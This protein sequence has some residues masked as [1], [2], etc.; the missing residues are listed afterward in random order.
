MSSNFVPAYSLIFDITQAQNAVVTFRSPH[1]FV[2]GEIVS[3]RVSRPY[4]MYQIN[5]QQGT[6]IASTTSTITVDIDTTEY[7]EFF[8][9]VNPVQLPAMCVPSASGIIPGSTPPTVCLEDAFDNVPNP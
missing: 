3:F 9:T 2:V 6:V 5:N 7:D 4:E 8:F 1:T